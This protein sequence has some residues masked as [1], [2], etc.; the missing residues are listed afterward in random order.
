MNDYITGI[1]AYLDEFYAYAY[2]D[3]YRGAIDSDFSNKIDHHIDC[4]VDSTDTQKTKR[5][6]FHGCIFKIMLL[7]P[8]LM[9]QNLVQMIA[10]WTLKTIGDLDCE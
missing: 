3:S 6:R 7:L 5:C 1:T 10:E 2:M 9:T 8:V 4:Y